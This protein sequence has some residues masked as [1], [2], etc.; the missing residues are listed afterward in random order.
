MPSPD[1]EKFI[2]ESLLALVPADEDIFLRTK[3]GE[4]QRILFGNMP[5]TDEEQ[6]H[7]DAFLKYCADNSL[8]M[9]AAY[10]TYE[11]KVLRYLQAT[12]WKYPDAQAAILNHNKWTLETTPWICPNQRVMDMCK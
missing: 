12:K 3:K 4:Y 11:R 2:P 1:Q 5:M 9:P 10:L 6:K 7:Y 8:E